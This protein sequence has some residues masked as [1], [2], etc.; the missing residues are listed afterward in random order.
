MELKGQDPQA[1]KPIEVSSRIHSMELKDVGD[2]VMRHYIFEGLRIHSMELK[3]SRH[4]RYQG[5]PRVRE[6]IQWN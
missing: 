3:G 2:P 4:E 6:S 1:T 5:A